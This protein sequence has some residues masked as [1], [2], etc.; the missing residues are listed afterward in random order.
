MSGDAL[1]PQRPDRRFALT[2]GPLL[3]VAI[4]GVL[5]F[6]SRS[7]TS[8]FSA[9]SVLPGSDPNARAI[10]PRVTGVAWAPLRLPVH[11]KSESDGTR[12]GSRD[13]AGL[14]ELIAGKP[15]RAL[16]T[17]KAA[18]AASNDPSVW[19]DLS[20]A[21][22]ETASQYDAPEL[23]AEALAAADHALSLDPRYPDALFN[24]A[25]MIERLG[26]S[27]D[28]RAAWTRY[29]AVDAGSGWAD[30]ARA[31]LGGLEPTKFLDVLHGEYDAIIRDPAVADA[32]VERDAFGARGM[33]VTRVLG[34][35][36]AAVMRGDE[37]EA[38]RHL[39][40]ARRMA[41]P[42][43]RKGDH[44]VERAVAAID[45]A[46]PKTRLLLANAHATCLEGFAA[47]GGSK[48][49]DGEKL[50][51]RA[52]A[53]FDQARSPMTLPA[54]VFAAIALFE[55]G[56]HLEAERQLEELRTTAAAEFP[57]YRG[58]VIWE[59]GVC[60]AA[61]ANW[62]P[63]IEAY[64]ESIELF[65]RI[66]E[67]G[68]SACVRRLLAV[69]YDRIGDRRT[70]WKHRAASPRPL[71]ARADLAH[72]KTNASIADGAILRHEW[73]IAASFLTLHGDLAR[74]LGDDVQLANTLFM[75]SAVRDLQGDVR[76]SRSD[77]ALA[78]TAGARVK[79]PARRAALAVAERRTEAMFA[80]TPPARA[81]ALLT[82]AIE[83]Q[84]AR[85]DSR[86][87]PGLLLQRARVRRAAG[88]AGAAMDDVKRGIA[89]LE[90]QRES[91][92][93]GEARWGAFHGAEELFDVAV[94]LAVDAGDAAGAFRFAEQARARALLESYGQSPLLDHRR[95]PAGTVVVE[96]VEMP[97]RLVIFTV[98]ASGIRAVSV[99]CPREAL[100]REVDAFVRSVSGSEPSWQRFAVTLHERLIRPVAAQIEN[101]T[102][103][104]FVP[105]AL[106]SRVAF[107]ALIDA[108]GAY[109][110][111]RHRI[112][113]APSAAAFAA[114]AERRRDARRPTSALVLAAS[115]SAQTMGALAWVNEESR[116]I[117]AAYPSAVRI[118]DDVDQLDALKAHA[119]AADVI[120]FG[121]HGIGDDSGLEP[122]SIVMRQGGRE[123]RVGV[124]EIGRLQ[125]R[126]T[127]TVV[128]AGCATARGERRASEGVISVSHGFLSAGASSVLSTLWPISDSDAAVFFPRLHR[129][130]AEGLPPAAALQAAQLESIRKGDVPASLWAAVQDIG[131]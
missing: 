103:L 62:G 73:H 54:L 3:A 55:Q 20:A 104:V 25:L 28:A 106:T 4:V 85:S 131:N 2:Y 118:A 75:L 117:A 60:Y 26:L 10:E 34:D 58:F 76:D 22:H 125:L 91:L 124:A 95:L 24:R 16:S 17:L 5:A 23:I 77:F 43:S 46:D 121:G 99:A 45:A 87:V 35:W 42:V 120:H 41:I 81:D 79:D 56:S 7:P 48:P 101:A 129:H 29:L 51:R 37:R 130:L 90:N 9:A 71:G 112:V 1:L 18:A 38:E 126:P 33:T 122:A 114:I 14:V 83:F 80:A 52:A 65:D 32:L 86:N 57:A 128:I 119:S 89:E 13:V 127:A 98:D 92:P 53:A 96:Y 64:T 74:R 39:R 88:N 19:S 116:R 109:L 50:L 113:I 100:E 44:M 82:E 47:L 59:L 110:L 12:G 84:A 30:E 8:R 111:E 107:G 78:K 102:S 94:E 66:G 115:S 93:E 6:F 105:A 68:N 123:R 49:V 61:R 15:R 108:R 31:H 70:A 69:V 63:A 97:T 36:G 11:P 27:D 72:E 40:V 67:N 21:Y